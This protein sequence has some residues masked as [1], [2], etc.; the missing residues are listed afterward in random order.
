MLM[1]DQL[2]NQRPFDKAFMDSMLPHHSSAIEMA[3]V[4]NLRSDNSQIKGIARGIIEARSKEIG[5]MMDWRQ[6][7][8]LQTQD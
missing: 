6:Q 3:S 5:Q 1:P 7:W 4:A 8:Y 2:A